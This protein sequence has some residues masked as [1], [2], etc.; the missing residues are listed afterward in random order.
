MFSTDFF[1]CGIAPLLKPGGGFSRVGDFG[2]TN[3][4]VLSVAKEDGVVV[5]GPGGA[6][7]DVEQQ[8]KDGRRPQE[9]SVPARGQRPLL[10][11][12]EPKIHDYVEVSTDILTVRNYSEYKMNDY[13]LGEENIIHGINRSKP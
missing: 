2:T 8:N 7:L 12:I 5:A 3:L 4:V 10:R 1:V 9:C 11:I 6:V 13:H